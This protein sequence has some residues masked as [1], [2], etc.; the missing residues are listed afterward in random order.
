MN[1]SNEFITEFYLKR[2]KYSYLHGMNLN[3]SFDNDYNLTMTLCD[4]PYYEGDARLMLNFSGVRDFKIGELDNWFE[5]E[6]NIT[7]ISS[8]QMEDIKYRVT[9]N[10][11]LLFSFYCNAFR[12]EVLE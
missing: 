9:E 4:Y 7:D 5:L 3:R 8:S 10:E 6:L 1:K 2:R 12:F 11:N